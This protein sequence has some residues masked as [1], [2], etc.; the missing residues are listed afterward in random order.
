M[1]VLTFIHRISIFHG[2]SHRCHIICSNRVRAP[3]AACGSQPGCRPVT[4]SATI[5]CASGY[6]SHSV[7]STLVS[8]C[9]SIVTKSRRPWWR[10]LPSPAVSTRS[11][12]SCSSDG[13]TSTPSISPPT[14]TSR[15][16]CCSWSSW[17]PLPISPCLRETIEQSAH[18]LMHC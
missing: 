10:G 5:F 1:H 7:W 11:R 4:F 16:I 15:R 8:C 9:C 2:S 14:A 6:S 3:M 18:C 13:Q 12:Y 17:R